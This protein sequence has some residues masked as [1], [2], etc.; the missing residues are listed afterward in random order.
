MERAQVFFFL[1]IMLAIW[2]HS[3]NGLFRYW[4]TRYK[5][6]DAIFKFKDK[7]VSEIMHA[8]YLVML[9]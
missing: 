6:D 4:V 2:V 5:F 3:L 8:F 9:K 1:Q 7:N